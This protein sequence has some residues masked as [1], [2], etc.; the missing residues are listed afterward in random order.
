MGAAFELNFETP[1]DPS[2]VQSNA[3]NSDHYRIRLPIVSSY[4]VKSHKM[5]EVVKIASDVRTYKEYKAV[6]FKEYKASA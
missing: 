1:D 2:P 5:E 4:Q 3:I 6:Y